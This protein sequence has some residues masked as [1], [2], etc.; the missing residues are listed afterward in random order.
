M[1]TL[2]QLMRKSESFDDDGAEMEDL[3]ELE[4]Q[5]K[6]PQTGKEFEK[7]YKE[8][9]SDIKTNIREDW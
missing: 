4:Q 1:S 8:F 3:H 7:K 6:Q 9:Y 5:N 2:Y